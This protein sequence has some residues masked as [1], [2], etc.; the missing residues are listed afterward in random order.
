M[1]NTFCYYSGKAGYDPRKQAKTEHGGNAGEKRKRRT[2]PTRSGGAWRAFCHEKSRGSRFTS[3]SLQQLASEYRNLTVEEKQRYVSI[4]QA[5]TKAHQHGFSSFG[6]NERK[7]Q[8][9]VQPLD[10]HKQLCPGESTVSGAIIATDPATELELQLAFDG[11]NGFVD[12]YGEL[13]RSTDYRNQCMNRSGDPSMQLE[14]S[15]EQ[16][17]AVQDYVQKGSDTWLVQRLLKS[18]YYSKIAHNCFLVGARCQHLV[19]FSWI[20]PTLNPLKVTLLISSLNE[21]WFGVFWCSHG[22][23][24]V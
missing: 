3:Q 8:R 15:K 14:L 2:R 18:P 21:F 24:G 16:V 22:V 20:P 17:K 12:A 6:T 7:R 4:G 23:A 13:K 9:R 19:S 10:K 11:M 1:F 5:G